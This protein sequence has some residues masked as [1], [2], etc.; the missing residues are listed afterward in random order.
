MCKFFEIR[1]SIDI[2]GDKFF[3]SWSGFRLNGCAKVN[4]NANRV[5]ISMAY[6]PSEFESVSD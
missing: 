3:A 1:R 6:M 4:K 2:G 5:A